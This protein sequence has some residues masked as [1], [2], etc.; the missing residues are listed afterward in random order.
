[1]STSSFNAR[2]RQK[3]L[4]EDIYHNTRKNQLELFEGQLLNKNIAESTQS[5]TVIYQFLYLEAFWIWIL[6]YTAGE[7]IDALAP[8]IA[9]IVDKF[10]EWNEVDQLY[11]QELALDFP[12]DGPYEY[13]GAPQFSTLSDYE[14]TLQ[15]LSIA[16]LLRDQRSVRR[17]I[18]VLRSHRGR[19][20]LFE[21][22][23][24]ANVEDSQDLE[25]CIISKPYNT[26]LQ[27]F[28]EEDDNAAL[29]LLQKYLKQW[30][31]AMK[32]HPRWYDEH[33]NIN[34][35]GYAAYYGY[36]AFEAGATVFILDLDD[37]RI[38]HLVYPKDLVDYARQLWEEGR[39]TSQETEPLIRKG[40]VEG[41]QPCSQTGF[42][43]TPAKLHSRSHFE[44]GQ[45][46]P[47]FDD[48]AYGETIWHWSEKQ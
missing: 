22:L 27:V 41:G 42:W 28:Y 29:A 31:P 18:H 25:T 11:Q 40:R 9:D 36:W 16:I 33:L 7:P 46:M 24:G 34:E 26:L 44:Q 17:I 30:Y 3:F 47:V 15:L 39:Y 4:H 37:S 10:E 5:Q 21:Q 32:N 2:R 6:D 23:I 19:D 45:I 14:D 8:R 38:D 12:E 48:A 13:E 1:M 20:G 43:E 35:E